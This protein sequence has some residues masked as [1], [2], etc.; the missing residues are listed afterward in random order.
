MEPIPQPRRNKGFRNLACAL[1]DA[2]VDSGCIVEKGIINLGKL[3]YGILCDKLKGYGFKPS[4]NS[5][6]EQSVKEAVKLLVLHSKEKDLINKLLG[7]G[8][9]LNPSLCGYFVEVL[10]CKGWKYGGE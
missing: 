9:M 8:L 5:V 1:R 6:L 4:N 3:N 7:E 10:E 2:I